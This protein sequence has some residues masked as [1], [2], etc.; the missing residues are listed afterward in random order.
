MVQQ[1][2]AVFLVLGLLLGMLFALKRGGPGK[3]SFLS[4]RL[5]ANQPGR[6]AVRRMRVL[7]RV[8]LT[9]HHSLHLV[10]IENRLMVFAASPNG[11]N[12]VGQAWSAEGSAEN[13]SPFRNGAAT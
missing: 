6:A 1:A 5:R 2:L 12:A 9:P 10:L 11:C 13:E 7:E 8:A 4:G 3:I